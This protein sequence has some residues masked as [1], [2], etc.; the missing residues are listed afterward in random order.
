MSE[1]WEQS[2]ESMSGGKEPK[3]EQSGGL[4]AQLRPPPSSPPPPPLW[5][6]L[7]NGQQAEKARGGQKETWGDVSIERSRGRN[8]MRCLGALY[9]RSQCRWIQRWSRRARLSDKLQT[10][11]EEE[12][13]MGDALIKKKKSQNSFWV[14]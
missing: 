5:T 8:K 14:T 2:A 6:Q 3:R 4:H 13:H 1:H 12:I 10:E 7:A 9:R 11:Q